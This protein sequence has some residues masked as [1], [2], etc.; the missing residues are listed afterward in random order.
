MKRKHTSDDDAAPVSSPPPPATDAV[1]ATATATADDDEP[2]FSKLGLDT[3]LLQAIAQ[4]KYAKPTLVQQKA[5]PLAINEQKDILAKAKTGSGKTAAY[6]LPIL[7][8]VLRRK[9]VCS[10]HTAHIARLPQ[11]VGL[12]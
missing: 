2:S 9:A 3:R 10:V 6:A 11:A 12:G 7:H 1:E 5:I 4:L 8:R